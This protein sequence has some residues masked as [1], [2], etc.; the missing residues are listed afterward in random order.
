[1]K[2]L[3]YEYVKKQIKLEG[4]ELL[5]TDYINA[6]SKLKL[7]C[8][9]GHIYEGTWGNF[10]QSKRCP[11]C[12]NEKFKSKYRFSFEYV[13]N[14]IEKE[15][16]KLISKEYKNAHIKLKI[17]CNRGHV[18][19]TKY[20]NFNQGQRCPECAG[21]K[22]LIYE[23]V[24]D[25]I[26]R[27]GYKL[28]SKNYI[29]SGS[30]IKIE[31]EK[32]HKY[33][34]KYYHFKAGSKCPH[35]SKNKK[36]TFKFI[37]HEVEKLGYKLL[38]SEYLNA[39]TKLRIECEKN[40]I[41][42]MRFND[43]QQGNRCPKCFKGGV[44]MS[45]KEVLDYIKSLGEIKITENDKT[46]IPPF[47]LDIVIPEKNLAVEY[48]GLYWH[49]ESNGKT[50]NYH[51]TKLEQ[52]NKAGYRLITIFEDEW[53]IKQDIV[54]NRI[55]H[56]LGMEKE[57]IYA[58]KCVIK[59]IDRKQAK[60]FIENYHIQGYVEANIKLGAFYEDELVAVMTFTKP[61]LSKGMKTTANRME[62]S[63]FCS[64]KSVIGIASKFLS[65]FQGRY[66]HHKEIYSFADRRWS[67]GNVY[68]KIGMK[69]ISYTEPN[70]FYFRKPENKR[71]HRFNF[72]KDVLREKL[73]KFDSNKT[74][75]QN[76]I[77]NGWF[78]IWDCGNI[79]FVLNKE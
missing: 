39:H 45:E 49:C 44:S 71:Y 10:S 31:C 2:K 68:E 50:K 65:Y 76:M 70:Y 53:L 17:Q 29:N 62:L 11:I 40:H 35:C 23:F 51:K 47:E 63:R 42:Q 69:R 77:E 57:R 21:N 55:R 64:S 22:K 38:S 73:E 18:Y 36:H 78:R 46:I 8:D 14:Q 28:L 12:R 79:K 26:E 5:S 59:N 1:M 25:E 30:K 13:K 7:R 61:S 19:E 15:N 52:C 75:Y 24:K 48:C 33:K 16:Y 43:L 37:Q 32:G 6:N 56:I 34:V 72:R 60:E 58:R 3:S 27:R 20:N 54:K 4:Y 9:K 67:E 66:P 41:F 74:E